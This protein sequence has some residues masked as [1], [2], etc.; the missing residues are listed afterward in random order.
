MLVFLTQIIEQN[1]IALDLHWRPLNCRFRM[2]HFAFRGLFFSRID[3][4]EKLMKKE[5]I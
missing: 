2:I 5:I 3:I 1:A 4:F